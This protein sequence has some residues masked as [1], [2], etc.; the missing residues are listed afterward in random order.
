MAGIHSIYCPYCHQYT[1]I[2]PRATFDKNNIR[3]EI[4]ECNKCDFCVLIER[5]LPAGTVV[6]VYPAPLPKP[7]DKRVP[8]ATRKDL[9][10]TNLC[11]SVSA[12]CGTAVM[13]RRALQGVCLDKGA[14]KEDVLQSQID[15][16]LKEGIITKDLGEW[17]HEVRF[18][19]N[20]AAHPSKPGEDKPVTKEDAEDILQLVEQFVKVLYIAPA[21]AEERRKLREKSK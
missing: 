4:A 8:D 7:V 6:A 15:W 3:R 18:V 1:Q 20:D 21:I 19:G 11:F 17:A 13:A 2:S 16:M 14:K 9:E 12:F 10:E 5:V